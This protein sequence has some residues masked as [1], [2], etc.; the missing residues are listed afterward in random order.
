MARLEQFTYTR[1]RYRRIAATDRRSLFGV[2]V[3]ADDVMALAQ[4]AC[5]GGRADIAQSN[6]GNLQHEFLSP[7]LWSAEIF[8]PKWSWGQNSHQLCK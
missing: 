4:Q 3:N 8:N 2:D 5:G 1:F 7:T 6:N